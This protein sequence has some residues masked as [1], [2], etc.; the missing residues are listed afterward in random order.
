[1]SVLRT[2]FGNVLDDHVDIDMGFGQRAEDRGG[3]ARPVGHAPQRNLRFILGIGDA[4]DDFLFQDLILITNQRTGRVQKI[5]H[6]RR[7]GIFEDW[8]ARRCEP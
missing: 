7:I 5:A 1:M 3:D 6:A 2:V 8:S 4:G